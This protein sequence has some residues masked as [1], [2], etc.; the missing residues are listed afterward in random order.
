MSDDLRQRVERER[1]R[2]GWSVRA[3]ATAGGTSNTTWGRFEKGEIELT[4]TMQQAVAEAF[5]WDTAWPEL[6]FSDVANDALAAL[7]ETID[8]LSRRVERLERRVGD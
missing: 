1:K 6:D 3:A 4:P 7:L 8:D 2:R 5:G